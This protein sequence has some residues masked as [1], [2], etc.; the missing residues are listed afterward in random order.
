MKSRTGTEHLGA[1]K[2]VHSLLS[3]CGLKPQLK[4]LDNEASKELL[5]FMLDS[6]LVPAN[7]H[8]RN[9]AVK[10]PQMTP[11]QSHQPRLLHCT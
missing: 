8:R 10:S 7:M 11:L 4:N 3:S 2:R 9:A 1:Y 5:Q 6:Q